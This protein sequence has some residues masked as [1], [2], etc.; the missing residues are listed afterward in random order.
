MYSTGDLITV[1]NKY[2]EIVGVNPQNELEVSF[3]KPTIQQEGRIWQFAEDDEWEIVQPATV[4]KHVV[5][6][7]GSDGNTVAKAWREI[8]FVAAGDGM[9]FCRVEDERLTEMPLLL[10]E[11]DEEEQGVPSNKASMHGYEEDGFIVPD[12]E[13]EDFTF[14]DPGELDA[15][16]AKFVLETHQA[17]HDFEKWHPEDKSGKDIKSYSAKMDQKVSIETDNQR[18]ANGKS[19]ISTSK[20]PLKRQRK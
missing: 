7:E 11:A 14:A 4:T 8:G 19:S 13:G 15:E 2:A 3:L 5:I 10:C 17:V 18:F 16:A 9:T 20:P 1:G 6:P 12:E